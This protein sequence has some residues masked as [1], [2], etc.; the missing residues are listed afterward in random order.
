M[1]ITTAVASGNAKPWAMYIHRF[2]PTSAETTP[3]LSKTADDA[4]KSGNATAK[5][6]PAQRSCSTSN[7]AA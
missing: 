4:D 2:S 6:S 7:P 3:A 5:S 1:D